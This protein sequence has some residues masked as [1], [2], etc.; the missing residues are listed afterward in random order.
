MSG[1]PGAG[2]A[3]LFG[4][5]VAIPIEEGT[6][7][8][9]R[10]FGERVWAHEAKDGAIVGEEALDE[11]EEPA[12]VAGDAD[13]AGRDDDGEGQK[14]DKPVEAE[15][16]GR[17]LRGSALGVAGLGFEAV[18][19]PLC[20]GRDDAVGGAFDDDFVALAADLPKAP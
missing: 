9:W 20:G 13:S 18:L 14:P 8:G 2:L 4:S 15:V 1:P 11:V 19:A 12:A 3:F 10:R 5:G 7:E 16:V 17:D 6:D